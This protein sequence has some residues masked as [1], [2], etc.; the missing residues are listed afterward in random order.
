MNH[1]ALIAFGQIRH[2]RHRPRTHA[3]AYGSYFWLLPMRSLQKA[4]QAVVRRN[5][6]GLLSFHDAD[7]GE[8]GPDALAWLD[9]LLASQGLDTPEVQAGEVWLQTFPRVLGHVFKPVS[10]WWVHRADRSL[11]AV[12]AE[13]NNT[14][15][16]RHSYV[17]HGP[18]LRLGHEISAG[19]A[20]HVS[21]FCPVQGQYRFRFMRT[22]AWGSGA[23]AGLSTPGGLTDRTDPADSADP[24]GR[25]LACV[26][27]DEAQG[28]VLD[29]SQGGTLQLLNARS[30]RHAFWAWPLMS[31]GVIARIH[32]HALRLWLKGV[33]LHSHPGPPLTEPTAPDSLHK[34]HT[35]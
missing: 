26:S 28:P 25:V 21:P 30:A 20:F 12:V 32:W 18:G 2:T 10:F 23:A 15:G 16:E 27:F 29:T 19:K 9:G 34:A 33:P 17:L 3:F 22:G 24:T 13:V 31:W 7:H 8:G 11:A 4:P 5:R 6:W 14:F 35:R 1:P